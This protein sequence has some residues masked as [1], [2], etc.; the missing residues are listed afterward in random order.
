MNKVIKYEEE[1]SNAII[2]GIDKVANIVKTTL[3]PKGRN[4]LIRNNLDLPIITNDGVTIAKSI[5]LKDNIEDAGASLMI[6][7]ANRTNEIA[8]DGTTTTTV[9]AQALIKAYRRFINSHKKI[10]P[11]DIVNVVEIQKEMIA[12][13]NMISDYLKSIAIPVKDNDSIKKVA[14]ISSG[15]EK[16]GELIAQAFEKAGEY[17][18]VVVSDSKTGS[19]NLISVQGM[20]LENGSVTPY[21]LNDRV[22]RKTEIVDA[23]LLIVKDKIDSVQDLFK[24]LDICI[25]V[26]KKLMILCDDIDL[27]PLQMILMNK[28]QGRISNIAIARIPGFGELRE[29][30]LE[31][32]CIA[33]GATII[34]RENGLTLRDFDVSHLGELEQAIITDDNTIFKFKDISSTG[35]N[36]LG[37]RQQ[38][39]NEL[40]ELKSN[41]DP[42]NQKQYERRISNLISGVSEIQIGGNSEIEIKD[43]KLRIEDA[44]NS[45]QSAIEEGIVAGGGFSFIQAF[46]YFVKEQKFET[47]G[48]LIVSECL[49]SVTKQILDNAGLDG[50]KLSHKCVED[51]IGYNVN[52]NKFEDL[53]ASGVINSVKV[54][55]YS[56]LNATSLA[57]TVI[58]MGG[59]IVDENEPEHN[60]LQLNTTAPGIL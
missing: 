53:I 42:N 60:V 49:L 37:G 18:S 35:L 34:S 8:G 17:G 22:N 26:G 3:G 46:N 31:D 36:L 9:L 54:D 19:D 55:R 33:T 58:T 52:T 29:N 38:R 56:L 21:L 4:V 16:I 48:D 24:V 11:D 32:L 10:A 47:Y 28:A 45:V 27:E 39:I 44:I 51:N 2:K 15:S 23:S 43:K 14:T 20:K 25:P 50:E 41:A 13:S 59:L 57:A 1:A 30:L 12:C 40:L 6:S 5:Q 7:A